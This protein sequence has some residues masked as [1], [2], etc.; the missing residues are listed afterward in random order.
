[1]ENAMMHRNK[2][3]TGKVIAIPKNHAN[4]VMRAI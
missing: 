1:L 3:T 4:A 2:N